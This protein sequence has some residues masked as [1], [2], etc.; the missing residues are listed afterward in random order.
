LGRATG[1]AARRRAAKRAGAGGALAYYGF[2]GAA[3]APGAAPFGGRH[4]TSLHL[5][6][7]LVLHVKTKPS[8]ACFCL[9]ASGLPKS[10]VQVSA[11]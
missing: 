3:A 8:F 10:V 11:S 4:Q 2:F 6:M 1:F 7:F 9:Q 5:L